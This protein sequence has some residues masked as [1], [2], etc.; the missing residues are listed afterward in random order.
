MEV[1]NVTLFRNEKIAE[2]PDSVTSR[3]SKHLKTLIEATKKGYKATSLEPQ[4]TA[5]DVSYQSFHLQCEICQKGLWPEIKKK[6]QGR[7]GTPPPWPTAVHDGPPTLSEHC[8]GNGGNLR[9]NQPCPSLSG[10]LAAAVRWSIDR[11]LTAG[12]PTVG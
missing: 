3:G 2:F 9:G 8:H 5:S 6:M 7:K 12:Q 11:R 4:D 10:W 1:K